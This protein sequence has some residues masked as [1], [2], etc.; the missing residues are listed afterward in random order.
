MCPHIVCEYVAYKNGRALT[1]KKC[2]SVL[3]FDEG[4]W[5][6]NRQTKSLDFIPKE[7]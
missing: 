1:C 3:R 6:K 2:K 5:K 7:D 4:K